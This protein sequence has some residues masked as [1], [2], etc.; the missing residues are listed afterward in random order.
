VTSINDVRCIDPAP[1][2][3]R[4]EPEATWAR[5]GD[6]GSGIGDSNDDVRTVEK[7]HSIDLADL[8]KLLWL[9]LLLV[10]VR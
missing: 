2:R 3:Y 9:L 10:Q 6:D 5:A 1:G 7:Y 4:E 8:G